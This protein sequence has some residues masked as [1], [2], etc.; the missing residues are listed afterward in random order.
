V[1]FDFHDV[2][3]TLYVGRAQEYPPV[4]PVF[5][6]PP[7]G[8]VDQFGNTPLRDPDVVLHDSSGAIAPE[9]GSVLVGGQPGY[10]SAILPNGDVASIFSPGSGFSNPN[11]MGFDSASCLLFLDSPGGRILRTC[12]SGEIPT[13]LFEPPLDATH[14]VINSL[15]WVYVATRYGGPAGLTSIYVYC[16]GAL[17]LLV[18][19]LDP[20]GASG[21][22]NHLAIALAP[23]G[24]GDA[25]ILYAISG[26]ELL[27]FEFDSATCPP[28]LVNTNILGTGFDGDFY[29]DMAYGPDGALYI[30]H[31]NDGSVTSDGVI[32]VFNDCNSNGINDQCD[33]DCG[34]TNGLC[35]LPSCGTSADCNT[36]GVLDTCEVAD[37][38]SS[39]ENGNG[40]PDECEPIVVLLDIKPGSY[41]NVINL[42][43]HGVIPVAILT[44]E[45]FEATTVDPDTVE[46]AGAT[47]AIR[48]N[49]NRLLAAEEDVDGD[50]DIDLVLHV[51]T[52][53]LELATGVTEATLTGQTYDGEEIIGSDTIEIVP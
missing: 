48:G 22:A 42:G 5:K 50:G 39:D 14:M 51:E 15:D 27:S 1:C 8:P 37:G 23:S 4:F 7:C 30:A 18:D 32:R 6:I 49:G 11:A 44:T 10:I 29:N 52:E 46:L 45:D 13:L 17:H 34:S 26:T 21:R 12:S 38:T 41:P 9:P 47:V 35:D 53:N 40:V 28:Q 31:Q 36:N 19:G 33:I 2:P 20:A 25:D 3:G 43:S 16:D 24:V